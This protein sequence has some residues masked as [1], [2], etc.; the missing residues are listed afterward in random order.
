MSHMVS[1]FSFFNKQ[2]VQKEKNVK[3]KTGLANAIETDV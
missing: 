1:I 2:V 3:N